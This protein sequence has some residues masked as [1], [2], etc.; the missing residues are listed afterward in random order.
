MKIVKDLI[1]NEIVIEKSRFITHIK[2]INS[3]DEANDFL[4][5]IKK[6]YYDATHNCVAIVFDGFARSSDDGEPSGTAGVPILEV[7]KKNDITDTICIVTRYFGG[8]K[9][10]AGG[11]IRAYSKSASEALK[12]AVFVEK[13]LLEEYI[14]TYDY[15]DISKVEKILKKY[16]II[17]ETIYEVKVTSKFLI[18][19]NKEQLI[20][21]L[22]DALKMTVNLTYL[23]NV[24]YDIP[25]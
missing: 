15:S 20:K 6:K 19:N 5:E 3:I 4:K 17:E 7:L 10:G 16:S 8:V 23:K 13:K 22:C 11:L 9:L 12:K 25:V 21:E 18:L 24:N 2:R 14:F 1:Q